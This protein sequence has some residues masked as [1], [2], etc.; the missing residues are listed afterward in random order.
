MNICET[1][2]WFEKIIDTEQGKCHRYPPTMVYAPE[3]VDG[4]FTDY[5]FVLLRDFCGEWTA[6]ETKS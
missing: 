3:Y 1:C 5:P 2:K 6:K 4:S